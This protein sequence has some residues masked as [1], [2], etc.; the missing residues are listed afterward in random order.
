MT[1]RELSQLQYLR[2]EAEEIAEELRRLNADAAAPASPSTSGTRTRSSR[3]D[4]MA[5]MAGMQET[6]R[7]RLE[8]R[9]RRVLAEQIRLEDYIAAVPDSLT[10]RILHL[11]YA[12]G[13]SWG[14]TA[15]TIGGGNTAEGVRMRVY[16]LTHAPQG[17]VKNGAAKKRPGGSS[18]DA[19]R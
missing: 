3:R 8:D 6:L 1:M 2:G 7:E 19:T 13:Y 17:G 9:R 18:P 11:H 5:S 15:R 12:R 16:R 14:R 10:R 4:R